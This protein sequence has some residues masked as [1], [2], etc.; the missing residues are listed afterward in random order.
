MTRHPNDATPGDGSHTCDDV[1]AVLRRIGWRLP[2]TAE[3]VEQAEGTLPAQPAPLPDALRD[4]A[5]V[6]RG[7]ARARAAIPPPQ[8]PEIDATLSRAA[9]ESG[10]LTP[11][12]LDRMRR[13][14]QAAEAAAR[15]DPEEAHGADD[16]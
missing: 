3:Q 6:L 9:R 2:V 1:A 13:D 8:S 16:R 4:P 15:G 12:T 7:T 14:R 11:E 10:R 5:A